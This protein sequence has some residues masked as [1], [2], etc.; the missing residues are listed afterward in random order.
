MK[1]KPGDLVT[2]LNH[3]GYIL[4][5][6]SPDYASIFSFNEIGRRWNPNEVGIIMSGFKEEI[7]QIQ[8]LFDGQIG[9]A[10]VDLLK[11]FDTQ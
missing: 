6:D 5:F 7:S 9:W 11:L 2:L 8:V 3:R 10:D 1:F 4:V